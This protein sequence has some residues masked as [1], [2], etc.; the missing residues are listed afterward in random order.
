M[1]SVSARWGRT[2]CQPRSCT[3]NGPTHEFGYLLLSPKWSSAFSEMLGRRV[4]HESGDRLS[5]AIDVALGLALSTRESEGCRHGLCGQYCGCAGQTTTT[6]PSRSVLHALQTAN[7]LLRLVQ[8]RVSQPHLVPMC[9]CTEFRP[10]GV[11]VPCVDGA[12][13]SVPG[14]CLS[15]PSSTLPKYTFACM[16]PQH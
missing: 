13:E 9:G 15:V 12:A 2:Q 4:F 10:V 8:M 6:T 7:T 16:L 14:F 5:V 1:T 3:R 11:T